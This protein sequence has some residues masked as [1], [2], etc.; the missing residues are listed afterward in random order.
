[1]IPVPGIWG[2]RPKAN[3][4]IQGLEGERPR[5]QEAVQS[6]HLSS[7]CLVQSSGNKEESA[8]DVSVQ[9]LDEYPMLATGGKTSFEATT[10]EK[11]SEERAS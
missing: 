4:L 8:L 7:T 1:M 9:R 2:M 11:G 6:K 3:A 5:G 10:H